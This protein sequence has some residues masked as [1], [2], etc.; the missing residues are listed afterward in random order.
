[1]IIMAVNSNGM[2]EDNSTI[3]FSRMAKGISVSQRRY[4][5]WFTFDASGLALKSVVDP[6]SIQPCQICSPNSSLM[7]TQPCARPLRNDP[8]VCK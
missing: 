6:T 7:F 8:I 1:M 3:P 4:S 2:A 5:Y